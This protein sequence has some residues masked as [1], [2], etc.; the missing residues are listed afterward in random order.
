MI[1]ENDF[2]NKPGALDFID[3]NNLNRINMFSTG[4][5]NM[6]YVSFTNAKEGP[7]ENQFCLVT[8]PTELWKVQLDGSGRGTLICPNLTESQEYNHRPKANL[9]PLGEYAIWTSYVGGSL[10]AYIVRLP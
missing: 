3:L 4:I 5:W 1:G 10:D 7:I 2:S 9:C 6:G 8:T